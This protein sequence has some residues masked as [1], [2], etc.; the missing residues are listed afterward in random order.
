VVGTSLKKRGD[1]DRSI[2]RQGTPEGKLESV[3]EGRNRRNVDSLIE[4]KREESRLAG[5][6]TCDNRKDAWAIA[7]GFKT[8]FDT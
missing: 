7:E 8:E 1:Q 5:E 6:C 2:W 3:I 4:K